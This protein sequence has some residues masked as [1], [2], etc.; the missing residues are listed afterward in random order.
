[1]KKVLGMGNALVDIVIQIEKDE[2]LDILEL[3]KGS[4]QLV[5]KDRS[6][7]VLNATKDLDRKL[8][9]GGSAANT[10]TGLAQLGLTSSFIAKISND[11]MGNIFK[12]DLI[13]SRIEPKLQYSTTGTGTAI[14]LIS[15]DSERT[16]ATHLGASVELSASDLANEPFIDADFFY[17]EGYLVQNHDLLEKAVTLAKN[18]NLKIFLDLASY[19]VVEENIDFLKHIVSN[20]VDVIF[21]NEEEAKAFTGKN[22]KE[23]LYELSKYCEIVVVK[24]GVEGSL[25]LKNNQLSEVEVIEVKSIDTTGAGDLYAA[26]FIFGLANNVSIETCGKLGSLLSGKVIENLGAKIHSDAWPSII[27]TANKYLI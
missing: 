25:I 7:K 11:E 16:F 23:A 18:N 2:I 10:I 14:T 5:N 8:K 19:N 3:P 24:I 6:K 12:S 9:S 20:Y 17:I 22:P 27:Q 15:E 21:A 4:M 26:G 1:M 13:Q